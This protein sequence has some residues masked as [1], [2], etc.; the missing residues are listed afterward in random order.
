SSVDVERGFSFGGFTCA[1]KRRSMST[2][3]LVSC[4]ALAAADQQ[5]LVKAGMLVTGRKKRQEEKKKAKPTD[6]LEMNDSD[7][8]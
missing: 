2:K 1:I 5:G 7:E 3:T 6:V 8:E 4:M